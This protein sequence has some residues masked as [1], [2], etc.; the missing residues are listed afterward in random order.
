MNRRR[1]PDQ[2]AA[3]RAAGDVLFGVRPDEAVFHITGVKERELTAAQA[4][5]LVFAIDRGR[6]IHIGR[7]KSADDRRKRIETVAAI[8]RNG[9]AKEPTMTT[10]KRAETVAELLELA[11]ADRSELDPCPRC[12]GTGVRATYLSLHRLIRPDLK[13]KAASS[14]TVAKIIRTLTFERLDDLAA[15][16]FNGETSAA[17]RWLNNAL[18]VLK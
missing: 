2:A 15:R 8:Y 1:S 6:E 10:T 3:I 14:A 12:Q 18:E 17:L 4:S 16:H 9:Q 13:T 5:A 11:G 7:P